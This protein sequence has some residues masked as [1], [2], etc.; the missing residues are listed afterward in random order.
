MFQHVGRKPNI[1]KVLLKIKRN[2]FMLDKDFNT[3]EM[4]VRLFGTLEVFPL[5][6]QHYSQMLSNC[7][8]LCHRTRC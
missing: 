8:S 3:S 2:Y 6:F 1:K 5:H 4:N 7:S